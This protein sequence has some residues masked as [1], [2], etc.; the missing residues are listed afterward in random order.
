[1]NPTRRRSLLTVILLSAGTLF[2]A[3]SQPARKANFPAL[4]QFSEAVQV[5]SSR[6]APS[7]VQVLVTRYGPREDNDT[8]HTGVV[9]D[10]QQAIGSGVI[11][12]PDGY[13]V[14]NAHVVSGAQRIRVSLV[15]KS[16]PGDDSVSA[17]LAQPFAAPQ[18]AT[19]VG[20]FQ[21]GDLALIKIAATGLPSLP[22]ADYKKLRQGQV[23]FAFGSRQGLSNS[24]SMGI[25]SSVARQ[26]DADTP[27][28]YIQTDAPI[29]PG[30]SGGPLAKSWDST[31]SS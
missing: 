16:S 27:F 25:V 1:M 13:I 29:N 12:D 7:V 10:R 26:P 24:V 8:G 4:D 11:V 14:T 18:D 23:V 2:G 5:L 6:V 15:S 17:A 3:D 19:L 9:L 28:I 21:E 30:D 20:T 31:R 22:F